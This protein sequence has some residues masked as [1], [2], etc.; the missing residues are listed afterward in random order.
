LWDGII[1][2][3]GRV[4][5]GALG[6]RSVQTNIWGVIIQKNFLLN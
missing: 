4:G 1:G 2:I 5:L 3:R 6:I